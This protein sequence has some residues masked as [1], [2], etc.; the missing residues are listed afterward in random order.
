MTW[1]FVVKKM[2]EVHTDYTDW[3]PVNIIITVV[4]VITTAPAIAAAVM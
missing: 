1:T 2:L 4:I 3:K